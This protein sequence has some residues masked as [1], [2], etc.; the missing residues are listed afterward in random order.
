M[1]YAAWREW[2]D[3]GID[4]LHAAALDLGTAAGHAALAEV[5]PDFNHSVLI[6]LP[7]RSLPL[8]GS[9]ARCA[10]PPGCAP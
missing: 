4:A 7:K 1:C 3:L 8:L 10:S 2:G 5:Y 6:F 9:W